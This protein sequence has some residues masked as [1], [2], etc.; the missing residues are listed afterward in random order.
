VAWELQPSFPVGII[1]IGTT[2]WTD[3]SLVQS[4]RF[5]PAWAK[6]AEQRLRYYS[7]QFPVAEVDSTYYAIPGERVAQAWV[8]RTPK[9]FAFDVKA[10]RLFTQHRTPIEAIP[11]D[12]REELGDKEN[13]YYDAIPEE[14]RA[15]L[16]RRLRA[17]LE[18]LRRES[19]LGVVLMQFAPWFI[20]GRASL[21]HLEHCVAALDGFQVA[22]EMRNKTWFSEKNCERTLE[23]E[24]RVGV[25]HVV[26]DEPQGS[27]FSIPP[28]WVAT[29]PRIAVVRLHGHNQATWQMKGLPAASERFDYF[30]SRSEL[31]QVVAPIRRLAH[32]AD[33]VHV[34]FNNCY[35]DN[36]QRNARTLQRM[37]VEWYREPVRH[38]A[39]PR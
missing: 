24:R 6:S 31:R 34:L 29:S 17:L 15:E 12:L 26:A 11:S 3:K 22:V 8:E 27:S 23:F 20:Y 33:E 16:W 28:V 2:S 4:R 37:L 7:H 5:Y 18:P 9:N 21:R 13:I 14:I 36:A 38:A 35:R 30:Y 32:S 19:K 25:A 1:R 39:A 10:F